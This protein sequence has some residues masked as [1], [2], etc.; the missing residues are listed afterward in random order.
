MNIK[1]KAILMAMASCCA[2]GNVNAHAGQKLDAINAKVEQRSAEI[3]QKHGVL[4]D[5]QERKDLQLD[6][7]ATQALSDAGNDSGK[8]LSDIAS[9]AF[10]TYEIIDPYEQRKLLIKMESQAAE[11]KG[12]GNGGTTPDYP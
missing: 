8:S 1:T 6:L 10:T 5:F 11:K 9:A 7:I 3:D 4:L 2:L 12:T